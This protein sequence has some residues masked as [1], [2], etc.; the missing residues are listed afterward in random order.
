[1]FDATL[2][3]HAPHR[4]LGLWS[5]AILHAG[6]FERQA[7]IHLIDKD[8]LRPGE[9]A[10]VQIHVDKPVF[11]QHGDRFVL[12]TTSCDQTLGGGEVI[13]AAPLHHRRRPERL[14]QE[15]NL[16]AQ[17]KLDEL[18]ALEVR[19][20]GK[21]L[22]VGEIA[23]RLHVAPERVQRAL[24]E[25]RL[26]SLT[27]F[28]TG[29]GPV[30]LPQVARD[31]MRATILAAV[32]D[33][34]QRHRLSSRGID[35]DELRRV[36]RFE[37]RPAHDEVI[38]AILRGLVEKEKV[39]EHERSWLPFDDRGEVDPRLRRAVAAVERYM[40]GCG[41]QTPLLTQIKA[42]ARQEGVGEK[43][44]GAI[45][46]H[47][48][49]AGRAVKIEQEH[50]HRQ[51]VDACREKLVAHLRQTGRAIKVSEFRDLIGGNR[52]ICLLL[53]N[54]FDAEGIT[55]RQGDDRILHPR[56]SCR[57][58]EIRQQGDP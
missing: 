47:L 6:T 44:V 19:K 21:P 7:R 32:T 58:D 31:Q 53:L 24:D 38:L 4:E 36:L 9:S 54:H 30:L 55:V 46:H 5:Q 37:R 40:A 35:L 22:T 12:R 39:R 25:G 1:M 57:M 43:D 28:E 56:W 51:V 13:D 3:L 16:I 50:L 8:R 2:R 11:L 23:D 17:G 41:L 42:V 52:K 14:V 26:T 15:L 29:E 20:A 49:A 10:I 18:I 48:V 33:Y 27:S 34:R 45:L